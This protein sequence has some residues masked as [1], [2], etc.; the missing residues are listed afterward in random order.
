MEEEHA[1][2]DIIGPGG[3]LGGGGGR[4]CVTCCPRIVCS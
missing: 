1:V 4:L 2:L 3:K